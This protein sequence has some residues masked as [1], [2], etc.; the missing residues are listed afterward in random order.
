MICRGIDRA[1]W[2]PN[3]KS[4]HRRDFSRY[5][6]YAKIHDVLASAGIVELIVFSEM[7]FFSS[8]LLPPLKPR[9]C[10]HEAGES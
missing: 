6:G 4:D 7:P 1:P 3:M 5:G 9:C 8:V 2:R 10:P